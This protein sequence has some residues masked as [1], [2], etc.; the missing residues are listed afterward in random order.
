MGGATH[1]RGSVRNLGD[2]ETC[3]L[4]HAIR[5]VTSESGIGSAPAIIVGAIEGIA[6]K[7]EKKS[8]SY[9]SMLS[10]AS[11]RVDRIS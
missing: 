11:M 7:S 10:G 2:L 4:Q 6:I 9:A 8:L 3:N 1:V 5:D